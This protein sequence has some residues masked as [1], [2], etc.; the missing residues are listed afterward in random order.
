MKPANL[1]L[2]YITIFN[3]PYD[4]VTRIKRVKQRIYEDN[5]QLTPIPST[6]TNRFH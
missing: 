2:K 3:D 6:W 4:H 1:P 5:H